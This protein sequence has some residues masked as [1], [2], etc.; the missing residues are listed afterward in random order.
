MMMRLRTGA[1]QHRSTVAVLGIVAALA[2][3]VLICASPILADDLAG[4]GLPNDRAS[5]PYAYTNR[6]IDSHDPYLLLH[7]HN[8][9][10]WYPWGAEA[11]AKAKKENKPIFLSIGYSTCYWCHVAERT[12]YS[13]R[14]IAKLMNQRFVNVKVDSEQRPDVDRVYMIARELMTGGG[15][16]WPNNLF[17]TPDLKPFYAGSYPPR[18]DPRAGPGFPTVLA[19]IDHVW[20]TDR[21]QAL[22][23]ADNVMAAMRRVQSAIAGGAGA[24]I[25]PDVWLAKARD[26]LLPQF[27]PMDGGL[28]DRRSAT[29]F[30]NPPRLALLLL[31]YRINQT[32]AALSGVLNTLDAMVFGGIHDQLGGGFHRY[33]T[34][35]SWSIPH[36]EKMLYD[37]AQLLQLYAEA[38]RITGLPLYGEIALETAGYLGRD[39]MAPD[40]GFSTARDA[41]L[42]GVEGEGYL[43][44]RGEIVSLLGEKE[45]ARFLSVYSLTPVPRPD[46]PDVVHPR[47]VNSEP[48]AVLRLRV[49]IDQTLKTTDFKEVAQMLASFAADRQKLLVAREQRA[50]PVRDEKI[51][52]SLNGLTIAALAESSP[53][54]HDPQLLNWAQKAAER[55]W[56]LSYD[57]RTGLLKH[58][59]YRGRV[60]TSGFLQDYASLGAAFMSLADVTGE[61]IWRDRARLL[62]NSILDR[63]V[64]ADGA[65]STTSEEKDLLIPIADDGDAEAPSGTSMA[66]D[67]LI[68]LHEA[69]AERRYL[70]AVTRAITRLS[71]QFQDHPE[72][73]AA[74]VAALNRHRLPLGS[75]GTTATNGPPQTNATDGIHVPVTADHVGATASAISVPDEDEVLVTIKVDDKFHINANPAS[76]DFLIPTTVEFKGIKPKRLD[77]PKPVRF[78]AEF[79]REGL[80]AYECSVAVVARFPK[81]SLSENRWIEGAVTVQAC[82]NRICLP[83]ST[84]PIS[85]AVGAK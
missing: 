39:M 78:T 59:I 22:G 36:F 25:K 32:S 51:V 69:S 55:I 45:A 12:I 74:S 83:P 41:Q 63:F 77:Y 9:V 48:P 11:F 15:G 28:A 10:D 52:I 35:P 42:N 29:K 17:L 82:T 46:F 58:E 16:G 1:D 14:D 34:E 33:S 27:D 66:I 31:D 18:D 73:W 53:V 4:S 47:D 64:R 85:A 80:D 81:G 38:F 68:R 72:S 60:Q 65:F 56:A 79:V 21:A 70:D 43:W 76:F 62:A 50:Q 54:L 20:N 6:L 13:N 57:Q 49:P 30:P 2:V 40:G 5:G 71:S 61:G 67:L 44:T 24:P 8:P 23:V 37:N 75:A 26:T 7:A 3:T 84:L 19:S